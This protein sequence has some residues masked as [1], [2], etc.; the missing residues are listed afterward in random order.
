[1]STID[2]ALPRVQT[3]EGFRARKYTDTRGHITIGYGFNIDA[4][5]SRAAA[6]ALLQAQ[7]T[8]LD[9]LLSE[10]SWYEDASEVR[11]SVLLELAFNMG[12]A[13]LLGFHK[14]LQAASGQ[15]WMSAGMQLR[16]SAWF[17]E[18]GERGPQLVGLLMHDGEAA[19]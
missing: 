15:D 5:I 11:R 8:E 17:D 19:S 4:G 9:S 2:I 18:V 12:L 7:L 1:M 6:A 14:M 13:G 10:Y 16:Q 3:N